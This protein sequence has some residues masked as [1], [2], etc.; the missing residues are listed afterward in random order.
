MAGQRD[1]EAATHD[2]AVH[3]GDHRYFES[4]DAVE[5]HAVFGFAGRTAELADVRTREES[6]TLADED[7]AAQRTYRLDLS[8][9][10]RE[11]CAHVRR[12]RV[13]G[14]I[15]GDDQRHLALALDAHAIRRHVQPCLAAPTS[16][17]TE[18]LELLERVQQ[19]FI[20]GRREQRAKLL[21]VLLD[22]RLAFPQYALPRRRQ[23]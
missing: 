22:A 1:L 9:R 6:R 11:A 15:V 21:F 7:H 8:Q 20:L 23:I 13:D 2:G 5:Q 10:Q 16:G 19:D 17:S 18:I 4:L 14:R 12:D 3:G